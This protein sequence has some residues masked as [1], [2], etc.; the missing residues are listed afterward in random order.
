LAGEGAVEAVQCAPQ[1]EFDGVI[2]D[3]RADVAGK[4]FVALSGERFDAHQF[5][6]EVLSR[7]AA[8]VI[9][10]RD[11]LASLPP[12]PQ[13]RWG[14]EDPLRA[15]QTLAARS[16]VRH[17]VRV[18]AITGSNGKT[19]TKDLVAAAL[20]TAGRV[21]AT[22]GNLNNHIGVP[23]TVLARRGDEDFLVAECGMSGFGELELL[24]RILQ[25]HVAVITNIGRAHLQQM[26]SPAG[27]A[28]AKAEILTALRA[29]G[30]AILNADDAFFAL[31]SERAGGA[32]RVVSFGFAATAAYRIESAQPLDAGRQ[33][34]QVRGVRFILPRPGRGNASNAAAALAVAGECGADL[35][36]AAAAFAT[37]A[38]TAGRSA[39]TDVGGVAVLDDTYNANPDSV[40][41]AIE[42]L[43]QARGGQRVAVLGDMLELGPESAALHAQVGALAAAAGIDALLACGPQMVHAVQAAQRAGMGA[44][45][46]H[47]ADHAALV[48]ALRTVVRAGD[49][50]LVKGSRG[51]H[52]EIV[53]AA[54]AA[55]VA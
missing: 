48:E 9:V 2:T 22:R 50:V 42:T 1:A 33:E 3:S 46:R 30:R 7:G 40:A 21:Y 27:V 15:L 52:M 36:R 41:L 32:S 11:A 17:P 12:G 54:L 55:G 45:A 6:P 19:T 51:S 34:L 26:G 39:W 31:L 23:L 53:I 28:R 47:F 10:R 20:A 4:L 35:G 24:S 8:G 29:E 13:P 16:L 37:A 18:V 5:V 38:F 44:R 43:A 25:P 14:V 49:A